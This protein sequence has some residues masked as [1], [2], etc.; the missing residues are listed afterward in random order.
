MSISASRYRDVCAIGTI[1]ELSHSEG[2]VEYRGI[3]SANLLQPYVTSA[4][5]GWDMTYNC[6]RSVSIS[7]LVS[8]MLAIIG[9][10]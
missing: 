3:S 4:P 5:I 7:P 8:H 9:L 1:A 2:L 6:Q 10:K